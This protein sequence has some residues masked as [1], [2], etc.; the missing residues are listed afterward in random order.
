MFLI[1][2]LFVFYTAQ[3]QPKTDLFLQNILSKNNDSLFQKVLS[4]PEYYRLQIIYTQIN[5]DK[6]N[7]P[8]F[9]SYYLMLTHC[10]ISILHQR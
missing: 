2:L 7:T 6:N 1:L 3:S 8:V 10:F 4:D 5:R 9:K